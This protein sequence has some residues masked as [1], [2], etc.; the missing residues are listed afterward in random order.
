VSLSLGKEK[1]HEARRTF[2]ALTDPDLAHIGVAESTNVCDMISAPLCRGEPG[3]RIVGHTEV[4]RTAF[5]EQTTVVLDEFRESVSRI[6]TGGWVP[7]YFNS[8][9]K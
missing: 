9:R 7:T 1:S 4:T 3:S 2:H 6:S 5:S 8:Y